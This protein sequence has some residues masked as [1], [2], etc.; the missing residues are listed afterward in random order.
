MGLAME[1]WYPPELGSDGYP[2]M[3]IGW[4]QGTI[5]SNSHWQQSQEEPSGVSL[6][7]HETASCTFSEYLGGYWATLPVLTTPCSVL[8]ESSRIM[9]VKYRSFKMILFNINVII[10]GYSGRQVRVHLNLIYG[11]YFQVRRPSSHTA[12][13][14]IWC[15]QLLLFLG[16]F[17]SNS[18]PQGNVVSFSTL[19]TKLRS[20]SLLSVYSSL[21]YMRFIHA[22]T[23]EF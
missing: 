23:H 18:Q 17:C 13:I 10:Q 12:I 4:A 2:G 20:L 5:I 8:R 16:L 19:K 9:L 15:P 7:L 3:P 21:C 11:Q 6:F 14:I 22:K 1:L